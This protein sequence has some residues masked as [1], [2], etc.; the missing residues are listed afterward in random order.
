MVEFKTYTLYLRD[1]SDKVRFEPALCSTDVEAMARARALLAIH[2][3]CETI[4]VY[5]GDDCLCCIGR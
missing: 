4:D 2:A 3:E 1:G 5:F